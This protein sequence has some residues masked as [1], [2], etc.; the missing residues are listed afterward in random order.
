MSTAT[1]CICGRILVLTCKSSNHKDIVRFG[2]PLREVCRA[3]NGRKLI[4]SSV[5]KH[6]VGESDSKQVV[7]IE[8]IDLIVPRPS[9]ERGAVRL[10]IYGAWAVLRPYCYQRTVAWPT[11]DIDCQGGIC[12][13]LS[14]FVKPQEQIVRIRL[15]SRVQGRR[16]VYI[17]AEGLDSRCGL[18]SL[19]LERIIQV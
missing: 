15:D 9:I 1:C 19:S 16:K 10:Y 14:R 12:R 4:Q 2:R 11:V 6:V 3:D 17:A 7:D 13:I 18:T 5:G 8:H